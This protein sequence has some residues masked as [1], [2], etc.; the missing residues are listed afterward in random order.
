MSATIDRF[1]YASLE[2]RTDRMVTIES[3]DFKTNAEMS[4][5]EKILCDGSLDFIKAAVRRFGRKARMAM[6]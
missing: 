4:L 6:I 3:V 2:P 5:D 1:A